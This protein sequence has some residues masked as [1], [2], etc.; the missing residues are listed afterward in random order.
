MSALQFDV[1]RLDPLSFTLVF[2][3]M[4]KESTS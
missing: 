4:A 3:S 2:H 1:S